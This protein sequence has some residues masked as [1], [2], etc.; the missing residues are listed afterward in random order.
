MFYSDF[1]R[2]LIF[3]EFIGDLELILLVFPFAPARDSVKCAHR[4]LQSLSLISHLM[5]S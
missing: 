3:H 2:R 5:D 4:A 1:D